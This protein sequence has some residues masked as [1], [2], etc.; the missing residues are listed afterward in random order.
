MKSR[1]ARTDTPAELWK[2]LFLDPNQCSEIKKTLVRIIQE[3]YQAISTSE[4]LRNV[5]AKILNKPGKAKSGLMKDKR[6]IILQPFCTCTLEILCRDRLEK[7]CNMHID[8]YLNQYGFTAKK[9]IQE[10]LFVHRRWLSIVQEG[11]LGKNHHGPKPRM[12]NMNRAQRGTTAFGGR[13]FRLVD[14]GGND[15]ESKPLR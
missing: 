14:I 6:L 15:L 5:T 13:H 9:G 10:A 12:R 1:R 4:R 11:Y 8:N 7:I 3:Q 2:A